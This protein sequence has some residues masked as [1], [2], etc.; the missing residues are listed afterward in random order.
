MERRRGRSR[1]ISGQSAKLEVGN[2]TFSFGPLTMVMYLSLA[3]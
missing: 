2:A 1:M 3:L